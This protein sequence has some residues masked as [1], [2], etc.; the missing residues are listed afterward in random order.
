MV[1]SK[2][3]CKHCSQQAID[4]SKGY[5]AWGHYAEL[6]WDDDRLVICPQKHRRGADG[7]AFID[8]PPPEWCPYAAEHVVSNETEQTSAQQISGDGGI[9]E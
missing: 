3:V 7:D 9:V 6:V 5:F 1:L 2:A 4:E 8:E